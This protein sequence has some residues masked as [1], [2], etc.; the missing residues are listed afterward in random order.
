METKTHRNESFLSKCEKNF[1]LVEFSPTERGKNK[2]PYFTFDFLFCKKEK[3]QFLSV[4]VCVLICRLSVCHVGMKGCSLGYSRV[5]VNEEEEQTQQVTPASWNSQSEL[6]F[7][8]RYL[9]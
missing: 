2:K 5:V 8:Y 3:G 9:T 4:G 7:C 6:Q 1:V